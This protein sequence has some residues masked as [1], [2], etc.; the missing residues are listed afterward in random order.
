MS[1][2][3]GRNRESRRTGPLT[4][5]TAAAVLATATACSG[6]AS[7]PGPASGE[8]TGQMLAYS[9]CM[10]EHGVLDFPDPDAS[11][12]IEV[13]PGNPNDPMNSPQEH[14]AD[15]DCKHLLPGGGSS[16]PGGGNQQAVSRDVKLAQ[17]MRAHG[18]ID[19]PDPAASGNGA[20]FRGSFDFSSPQWQR[21]ERA[22]KPLAPAGFFPSTS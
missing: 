16:T 2:D 17:C 13:T 11:G 14:V 5:V 3:Y 10:R 20:S 15:N 6:P 8:A 1:S 4:V 22:C 18:A 12:N 7:S 19:F 9:R 21:A